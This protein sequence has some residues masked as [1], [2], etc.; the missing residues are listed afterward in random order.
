MILVEIKN[1]EVF[2]LLKVLVDLLKLLIIQEVINMINI[3]ELV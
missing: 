3:M 1:L 2:I